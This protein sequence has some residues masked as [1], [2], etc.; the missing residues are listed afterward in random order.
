MNQTQMMNDC[1]P[2]ADQHEQQERFYSS[3]RRQN[4]RLVYTDPDKFFGRDFFSDL[5]MEQQEQM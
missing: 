1:E 5:L 2:E 4:P 3:C